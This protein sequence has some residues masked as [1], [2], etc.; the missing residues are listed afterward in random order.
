MST[1]IGTK[2]MKTINAGWVTGLR[3]V[4]FLVVFGCATAPPPDLLSAREAY[5]RAE[6]STAGKAAPVELH[7]AKVALDLAEQSFASNP[8]DEAARDLSYVAERK[9]QLAEAAG[10]TALAETEKQAA[11]S[12]YQKKQAQL[13]EGSKNDL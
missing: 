5:A 10:T 8:S 4:P 6:R 2:H 11:Q 3:L 12:A 1:Q 7:K 13:Y 9:A